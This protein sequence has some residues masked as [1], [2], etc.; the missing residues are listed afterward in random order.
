MKIPWMLIVE[1]FIFLA[2]VYIFWMHL[3]ADIFLFCAG[4]AWTEAKRSFRFIWNNWKSCPTA[5]VH[6]IW[7]FFHLLRFILRADSVILG[8]ESRFWT[9][10][11]NMAGGQKSRVAFAKITFKKPHI[12]LLDEPSNHLVSSI[13][14]FYWSV[15]HLF[16]FCT[17]YMM[18]TSSEQGCMHAVHQ[19]VTIVFALNFGVNNFF[20]LPASD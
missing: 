2:C 4:S 19:M 11:N 14:L 13:A 3:H 16:C 20:M 18:R 12:L 7:Y 8:F 6:V 15:M 1:E 5:D 10:L 17:N 9:T